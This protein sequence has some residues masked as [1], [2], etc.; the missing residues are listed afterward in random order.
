M[1]TCVQAFDTTVQQL[2]STSDAA[3]VPPDVPVHGVGHSNGSLMHLFI[4]SLQ[5][6]SVASNVL[7]SYNNKE[8]GDAIPIPGAAPVACLA[9]M[10]CTRRCAVTAYMHGRACSRCN[11]VPTVS[12]AH[13]RYPEYVAW[14]RPKLQRCQQEV[15]RGASTGRQGCTGNMP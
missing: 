3:A 2:R 6:G 10:W 5:P 15:A 12:A 9:T 1:T 14:K 8:V 11:A 13:V 4:S 7:M